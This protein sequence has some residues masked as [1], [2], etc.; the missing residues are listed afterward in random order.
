M[1]LYMAEAEL[2]AELELAVQLVV[3]VQVLQEGVQLQEQREWMRKIRVDHN[4]RHWDSPLI[5]LHLHL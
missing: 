3:L 2:L 4:K 1:S 5:S